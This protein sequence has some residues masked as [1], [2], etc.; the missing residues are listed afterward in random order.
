[1]QF[2]YGIYS[3]SIRPIINGIYTMLK[4]PI[5]LERCGLKI[6]EDGVIYGNT[7]CSSDS[8]RLSVEFCNTKY[9]STSNEFSIETTGKK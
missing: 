1:M 2:Y 9:C 8:I 6:K 3:E 5:E 4:I 7:T